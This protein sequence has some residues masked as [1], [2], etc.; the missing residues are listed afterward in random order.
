M[1]IPCYTIGLLFCVLLTSCSTYQPYSDVLGYGYT[2]T[3]LAPDIY[4][5]NFVGDTSETMTSAKRLAM[6]RAAH[7]AFQRGYPYFEIINSRE[8]R[9][10]VVTEEPGKT[11]IVEKEKEKKDKKNKKEKE[12]TTTITSTPSEYKI[13]YKPDITITVKMLKRKT[14]RSLST[15]SVL[16]QARAENITF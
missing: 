15:D 7:I 14:E 16:Q 6:Y 2:D 8:M 10:E 3:Q 9:R 5:I 12:R 4:E 13:K 1:K 11:E